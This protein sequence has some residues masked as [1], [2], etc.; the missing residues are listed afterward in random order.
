M[1]VRNGEKRKLGR[2]VRMKVRNGQKRKV[3]EFE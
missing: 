2:G 1:K 3:E